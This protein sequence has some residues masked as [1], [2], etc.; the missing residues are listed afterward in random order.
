MG[1]GEQTIRVHAGT[2]AEGPKWLF[3]ASSWIHVGLNAA[4]AMA[5]QTYLPAPVSILVAFL[6][7]RAQGTAVQAT[8]RSS[9]EGLGEM[10]RS[11]LVP[12]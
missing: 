8:Q 1:T 3:K 12:W 4:L 10:E 7:W 11:T 5:D 6:K 9:V 2:E